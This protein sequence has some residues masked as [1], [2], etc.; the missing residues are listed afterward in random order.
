MIAWLQVVAD[1]YTGAFYPLLLYEHG[2]IQEAYLSTVV[3]VLATSCGQEFC[4]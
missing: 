3:L 1:S 4:E 2:K